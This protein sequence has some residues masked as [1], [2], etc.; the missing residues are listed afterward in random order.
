[1]VV[2]EGTSLLDIH[3]LWM[4]EH[5]RAVLELLDGEARKEA[6]G[7]TGCGKRLIWGGAAL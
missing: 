3:F 7:F 1:M 6:H 2:A 4:P 5:S